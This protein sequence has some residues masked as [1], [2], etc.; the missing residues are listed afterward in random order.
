[1]DKSTLRRALRAQRA[2]LPAAQRRALARRACRHAQRLLQRGSRVGFYWPHG[3]E[4]DLRPLIARALARGCQCY[5][6]VVPPRG[7]RVLR[8]ARLGR[9]GPMRRNRYGI[10]EPHDDRPVP[11]Y[12]LDVL[13]VPLVGVD[14]RGV[15]LGMGG[16]YYDATLAQPR[17][18]RGRRAPYRVGVGYA[19]QFCRCV[20]DDPWDARLDAFVS[21][22]G[23]IALGKTRR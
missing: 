20:P 14:E 2:A 15:R 17:Q 21:D 6:P 1:M 23:L 7:Q 3:S 16:G 9:G 8:F 18:G 13:F 11:V 12:A 5:L 22:K 4:L 19:L 10:P